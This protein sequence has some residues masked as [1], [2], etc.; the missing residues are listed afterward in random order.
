[1]IDETQLKNENIDFNL[2]ELGKNLMMTTSSNINNKDLF[3]F[4]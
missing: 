4:R 3:Y 2:L 1:M